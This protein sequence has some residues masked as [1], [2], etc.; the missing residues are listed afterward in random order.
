MA[1]PKV[2]KIKNVFQPN[3]FLWLM[4]FLNEKLNF[5]RENK[6]Y[7]YHKKWD[8]FISSPLTQVF[9]WDFFSNEFEKYSPLL[10]KENLEEL[11]NEYR[12]MMAL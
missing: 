7:I 10:L 8:F 2:K 11:W 3:P 4:S 1:F 9:R 5:S 6:K 12:V